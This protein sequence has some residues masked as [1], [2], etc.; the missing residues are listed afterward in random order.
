MAQYR[1]Y[2]LRL[3]RE[4]EAIEIPAWHG[5]IESIQSGQKWEFDSLETFVVFLRSQGFT[6]LAN[7]PFQETERSGWQGQRDK[8]A[9]H[10]DT[11]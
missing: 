7:E 10:G 4:K 5:E 11:K 9:R 1:S 3:W 2:L 8:T 6:E